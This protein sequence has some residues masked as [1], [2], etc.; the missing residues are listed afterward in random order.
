MKRIAALSLLLCACD[1]ASAGEGTLR[2]TAWGE[3]FI[4]QGIPTEAFVDGWSVTF[5]AF[6]VSL[7]AIDADG[8]RMP[9][10][11]VLDLSQPSG[12]AGQ[13]LG[14]LSVP[15]GQVPAL[16]W[17]LSTA[18]PEAKPAS[19]RASIGARSARR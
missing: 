11:Y 16:S 19:V 18:T 9:G 8:I 15:A 3:D 13:E 2:V 10:S 7:D 1:G 5:D 17:S 12:G 14:V 6:V 4:E